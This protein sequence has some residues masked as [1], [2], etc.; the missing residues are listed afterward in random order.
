MKIFPSALILSLCITPLAH[1]QLPDYGIKLSNF[2]SAQTWEEQF[3]RFYVSLDEGNI[4]SISNISIRTYIRKPDAF[5]EADSIENQK[6][7][8][9][10]EN[11]V[12][13]G[14][15]WDYDFPQPL[16]KRNSNGFSKYEFTNGQNEVLFD[17]TDAIQE[18]VANASVAYLLNVSL[19]ITSSHAITPTI[20]H[21]HGV[22]TVDVSSVPFYD[23]AFY[24]EKNADFPM[25]KPEFQTLGCTSQGKFRQ[26]LPD[27]AERQEATGH[28]LRFGNIFGPNYDGI[29]ALSLY[30]HCI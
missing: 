24:N 8:R 20:T 29:V 13:Q 11:F 25:R 18:Q 28:G 16:E 14:I 12:F 10:L 3:C 23:P 22:E 19:S 17:V 30:R 15:A 21:E 9:N 26:Q 6:R 27:L 2:T 1:G 5:I 4:D 7:S